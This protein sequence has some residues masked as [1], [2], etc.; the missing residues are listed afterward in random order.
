MEARAA[1]VSSTAVFHSARSSAKNTP[2][3]TAIHIARRE[4]AGGDARAPAGH[5]QDRQVDRA[6]LGHALEQIGVTCEID[7]RRAADDEPELLVLVLVL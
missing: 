3:P 7:G 2:P 5:G 1:C 6:E 4:T